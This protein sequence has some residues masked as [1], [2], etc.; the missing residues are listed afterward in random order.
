MKR[1]IILLVVAVLALALPAFAAD[2]V[3]PIWSAQAANASKLLS[4]AGFGEA[5]VTVAVMSG[6]P[7]GTVTIYYQPPNGLPLVSVASTTPSAWTAG[8]TA[9]TFRGPAGTALLVVLSGNTTG[10]VGAVAVLK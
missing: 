9:K 5:Q 1:T 7:D 8:T 10:T 2:K 4:T 6:S 3:E